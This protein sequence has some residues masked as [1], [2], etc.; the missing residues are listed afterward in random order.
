MI[1][2]NEVLEKAIETAEAFTEN[3]NDLEIGRAH[4]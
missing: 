1:H 4:V 2:N 3:D